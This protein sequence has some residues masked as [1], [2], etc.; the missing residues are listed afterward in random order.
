MWAYTRHFT[1]IRVKPPDKLDKFMKGDAMGLFPSP[2]NTHLLICGS[3]RC[4]QESS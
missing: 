1:G 3:I 2:R 4:A